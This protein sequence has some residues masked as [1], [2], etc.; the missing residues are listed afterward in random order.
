M[1]RMRRRSQYVRPLEFTFKAQRIASSMWAWVRGEKVED[2]KL[3]FVSLMIA[4]HVLHLRERSPRNKDLEITYTTCLR[5]IISL[6]SPMSC[7]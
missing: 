2:L 3:G 4:E 6:T 7:H 5:F 1:E